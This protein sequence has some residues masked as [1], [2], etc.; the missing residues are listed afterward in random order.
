MSTAANGAFNASGNTGAIAVTGSSNTLATTTGV[1]LN[2]VNTPIAAAGLNFRSISANG[3]PNGIVLNNTGNT[4]SLSVAGTGAANSGGTIQ[5]IT[6]EGVLLTS[7]LSPSFNDVNIQSTA[8]SGV[9]GTPA[10]FLNEV[11]HRF[12]KPPL[13]IEHHHPRA[14]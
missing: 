12:S 10:F 3:A 4:G 9:K 6:N 8:K 5:N 14:P 1:A 11:R 13:I 2:V 7:T